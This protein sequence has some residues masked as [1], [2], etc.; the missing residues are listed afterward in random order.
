MIRN[1]VAVM[2]LGLALAAPAMAAEDRGGDR[3]MGKIIQ[4][5]EL[6][7]PTAEKLAAL[8]TRQREEAKTHQTNLKS[9]MK[10]LKDLIAEDAGANELNASLDRIEA[11]KRAM[12]DSQLKI[13]RE[14]RALLGPQKSA[15]LA[16]MYGE[17]MGKARDQIREN[18]RGRGDRDGRENRGRGRN[19]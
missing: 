1:L 7:A 17:M 15:Q 19:R 10:A 8:L 13:S 11:A 9:E 3:M 14:I 5:L 6:D 4:K 2:A 16:V 18:A 12:N